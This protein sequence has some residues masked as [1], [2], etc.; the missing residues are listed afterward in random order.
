MQ[1]IGNRAHAIRE[2][3][4]SFFFLS[5]CVYG[6][7]LFFSFSLSFILYSNNNYYCINIY[8]LIVCILSL[9][10]IF[11]IC[12][13]HCCR[14]RCTTH[15]LLLNRSQ[16]VWRNNICINMTVLSNNQA[17]RPES[18]K[19]DCIWMIFGVFFFNDSFGEYHLVKFASR[20]QCDMCYADERM[21]C[22]VLHF[23]RI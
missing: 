14:N 6:Y 5:C 4:V 9:F 2:L 10:F 12:E 18:T 11:G 22:D 1:C 7:F 17:E 20:Y 13:G 23:N 3:L 8:E 21:S 19:C 16:P 15:C